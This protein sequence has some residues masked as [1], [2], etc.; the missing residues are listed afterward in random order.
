M[1]RYLTPPSV[2]YWSRIGEASIDVT[3]PGIAPLFA[4]DTAKEMAWRQKLIDS[5]SG[6]T[7]NLTGDVAVDYQFMVSPE[8]IVTCDIDNFIIPAGPSTSAAI[9]G[10][11]HSSPRITTITATKSA[12]M[13]DSPI[14]T[15]VRVWSEDSPTDAGRFVW[16]EGDFQIL[17]PDDESSPDTKS[18]H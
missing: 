8:Q 11:T 17:S 9:F 14:R 15:R 1:C 13:K 10:S 7:A 16:E 3:I 6:V 5:T 12:S 18:S 4:A 2:K